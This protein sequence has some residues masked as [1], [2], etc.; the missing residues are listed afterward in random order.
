M[1]HVVIFSWPFAICLIH[2][3]VEDDLVPIWQNRSG[4]LAVKWI[5][6]DVALPDLPGVSRSGGSAYWGDFNHY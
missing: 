3:P 2:W 5:W 1:N 6:R 4:D